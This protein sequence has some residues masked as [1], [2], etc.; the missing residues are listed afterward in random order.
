M[1]WA[2]LAGVSVETVD[3]RATAKLMGSAAFHGHERGEI[4]DAA[5][6]AHLRST[7]A[8]DL[9]DAQFLD[10]WNAIFLGEMAGIRDVL[11]RVRGERPLYVFSNTNN[12]HQAY[13]SVQYADLLKPFA[14]VFVSNELGARKPEPAAFAAVVA[15]IGVPAQRVLF[16]DDAASNVQGARACGLRAV[17]VTSTADIERSLA[18]IG[19]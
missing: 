13:W 3:A 6:F 19:L 12:A 18:D 1:R 17:Q 5:F 4:T 9:T 2:Q 10:G 16:F 8:L 7:L 11:A 14:K 15:G